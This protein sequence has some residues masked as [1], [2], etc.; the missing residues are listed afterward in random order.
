[1][2]QSAYSAFALPRERTFVFG[3]FG[4]AYRSKRARL[5]PRL[6]RYCLCIAPNVGNLSR[7]WRVI[8]FV[9]LQT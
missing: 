8:A 7:I 1:M 3:G 6:E 2:Q 9:S 4:V 5:S